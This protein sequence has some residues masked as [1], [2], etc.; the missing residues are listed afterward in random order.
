MPITLYFFCNRY[1]VKHQDLVVW[2]NGLVQRFVFGFFCLYKDIDPLLLKHLSSL[3]TDF[4]YFLQASDL[5]SE[6]TRSSLY[7][8]L[9]HSRTSDMEVKLELPELSSKQDLR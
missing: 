3:P 1:S 9:V 5:F 7:S 2:L 4:K 6:R 8:A